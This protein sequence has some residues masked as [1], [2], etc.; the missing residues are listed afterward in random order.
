M[1]GATPKQ[2]QELSVER[3]LDK[4]HRAANGMIRA[5]SQNFFFPN[6]VPF[7]QSENIYLVP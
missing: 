7:F 5:M 1:L 6:E 4:V 3:A 2:V